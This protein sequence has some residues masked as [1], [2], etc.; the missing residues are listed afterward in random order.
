[1]IVK[2]YGLI[3]SGSID[4]C[5]IYSR[6]CG[7]RHNGL[8]VHLNVR[9]TGVVV[10]V[11]RIMAT[12]EDSV[13]VMKQVLAAIDDFVKEHQ[14]QNTEV[15][16][17]CVDCDETIVERREF[18][19]VFHA[20][21]N[22]TLQQKAEVAMPLPVAPSCPSRDSGGQQRRLE[23]LRLEQRILRLVSNWSPLLTAFDLPAATPH[24]QVFLELR[25]RGKWSEANVRDL[26]VVLR[27][28]GY[29]PQLLNEME[30]YSARYV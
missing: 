23:L 20:S 19:C 25:A 7:F 5:I 2:A 10:E 8:W 24:D 18:R 22:S 6:G 27:I 1:M 26:L 3:D 11:Q 28:L 15:S 14:I 12:P 30:D 9:V 21:G 4:D 13:K 29:D 17:T 16:I